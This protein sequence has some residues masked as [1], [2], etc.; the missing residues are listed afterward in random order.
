[1]ADINLSRAAII[2]YNLV[3]GDTFAPP[4]VSFVI[5]GTPEN[6]SASTLV[7]AIKNSGKTVATLAIGSGIAVDGN[8]LQY[9]IAASAM[10]TWVPGSYDYDVKKTDSG[11]VSTIQTGKILLQKM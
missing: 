7:M 2:N 11:I 8:V 10:A 5:D 1:M 9:S 4:P 6:F 3:Q